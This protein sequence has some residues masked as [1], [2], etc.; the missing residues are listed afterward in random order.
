M[1]TTEQTDTDWL[2]HVRCYLFSVNYVLH[3]YD[4]LWVMS[5]ADEVQS[6]VDLLAGNDV[7]EW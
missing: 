6:S 4:M 7:H 1:N 5:T 2:R 3:L